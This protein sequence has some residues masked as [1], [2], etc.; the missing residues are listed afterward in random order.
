MIVCYQQQLLRGLAQQQALEAAQQQPKQQ[1]QTAAGLQLKWTEATQ[2]QPTQVESLDAIQAEQRLYLKQLEKEKAERE[3]EKQAQQTVSSGALGS[4]S[5]GLTWGAGLTGPAWQA[6]VNPVS[7]SSSAPNVPS[8]GFWD[9]VG[10]I[11][12]PAKPIQHPGA[13]QK[14]ANQQNQAQQQ[15]QNKESK[16][17]A[18]RDEMAV[19]KLFS[20]NSNNDEFM[21]WCTQTLSKIQSGTVDIP[22]F[23]AFLRDIDSPDEVCEYI[24]LY[25][26]DS[27][28]ASD[29][30]QQFIERRRHGN[31]GHHQSTSPTPAA[32]QDFQQVKGIVA[33]SLR[34]SCELRKNLQSKK[35]TLSRGQKKS[36]SPKKAILFNQIP[37]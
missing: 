23:V 6:P 2:R 8:G 21:Q 19:M 24:K 14:A 25:L 32:N 28:E 29:F 33:I 9:S 34:Q 31:H 12:Q 1:Q 16:N 4:W 7:N 20:V 3:K 18:K 36:D 10:A 37:S 17:K 22:T 35:T 26:G 13:Q 5:Q 30:A 11:P 15:Q 27:A